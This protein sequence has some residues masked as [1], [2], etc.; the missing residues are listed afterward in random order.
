MRGEVSSPELERL[1]TTNDSGLQGRPADLEAVRTAT[2]MTTT[3]VP[4]NA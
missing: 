3:Q 1:A 2:S 4:G